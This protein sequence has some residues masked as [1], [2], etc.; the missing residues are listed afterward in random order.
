MIKKLLLALFALTLGLATAQAADAKADETTSAKVTAVSGSTAKFEISG[1]VAAW[2]K[3]GAFV[4]AVTDKGTLVLRG[5]KVTAI[6]GK[7]VTVQS[8]MAKELK[9]GDGFKL[10]KGKPTAGC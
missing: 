9:V 4:R 5:A 8:A 1:D 3:K 10:S 2:I 7:T 6:D